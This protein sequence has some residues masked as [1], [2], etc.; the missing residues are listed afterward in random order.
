MENW[1]GQLPMS[2]QF[3]MKRFYV[4]IIMISSQ[5]PMSRQFYMKP[6]QTTTGLKLGQLPMSRQFY[7]KPTSKHILESQ[8]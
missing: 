1:I 4:S 2:R 5:L 7:M 8:H 6:E 3:Y